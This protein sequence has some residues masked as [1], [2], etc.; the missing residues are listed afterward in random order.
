MYT[1]IEKQLNKITDTLKQE[2]L[3]AN[4]ID[5]AGHATD[6]K[7]FNEI[8]DAKIAQLN[9]IMATTEKDGVTIDRY[10]ANIAGNRID[11]L[12]QIKEHNVLSPETSWIEKE[13]KSTARKSEKTSA[14]NMGIK[15]LFSMFQSRTKINSPENNR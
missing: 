1:D 12:E 15:K 10:G 14:F 5:E 9:E 8:I 6:V 2:L 3:A 11:R 7:K 13:E 4:A